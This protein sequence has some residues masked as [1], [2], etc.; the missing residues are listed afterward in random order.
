MSLSAENRDQLALNTSSVGADVGLSDIRTSQPDPYASHLA[1]ESG[2]VVSTEDIYDNRGQLLIRRHAEIDPRRAQLLLQ[3][4]LIKPLEEQVQ[5]KDSLTNASFFVEYSRF[6]ESHRDIFAAQ[7]HLR[8]ARQLEQLIQGM[9]LSPVLAQ[10]M[11]VMKLRLPEQFQKALFSSWLAALIAR[12]M[13][14]G[15]EGIYAAFIAGLTHDIGFLHISPEILNKKGEASANDW[16]AIQSH[17]VIGQ[18]VLKGYPELPDTVARAV[19]EHHERC[20]GTGY[21]TAK[22]ESSLSVIGQIIAMSDAL[23]ALRMGV[24][25]KTGRNLRDALPFLR[26]NSNTHFYDIYRVSVD[27]LRKSG[28]EPTPVAHPQGNSQYVP[29]MVKRI[30]YLK[31]AVDS[32]KSI[33]KTLSG[34]ESGPKGKVAARTFDHVLNGITTSGMARD[35]LLGWVELID[36]SIDD[37]V[38]LEINEI[39]LMQNELIWQITSAQRTFNAFLERECNVDSQLQATL[40]MHNEQLRESLEKLRQ[41]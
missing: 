35:E 29:L 20:D 16:R 14:L 32:I 5:V 17:V 19:L 38:L 39:E 28:L 18:M 25:A 3:H 2:N 6:L 24:F 7:R 26:L 34:I 1:N 36:D 8:F 13:D 10:K 37:S 30:A 22:D 15:K 27:I 21:P 23:Q 9:N 11:T 40:R 31:Q 33:A 12:E 41:R 4:R